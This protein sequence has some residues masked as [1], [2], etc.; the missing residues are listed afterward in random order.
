[1]A[2]NTRIRIVP[3]MML[4]MSGASFASGLPPLRVAPELLRGGAAA[5]APARAP[6]AASTGAGARPAPTSAPSVPAAASPARAPAPARAPSRTRAPRAEIPAAALPAG[7]T[8]VTAERIY[9]VRGIELVAD[10]DA[11]L[12]RADVVVTADKVTY[13]EPVDEVVAEGNVVMRQG[14]DTIEGPRATLVVG[15]RVGVVES[16]RYQLTRQRDPRAEADALRSVA[17]SGNADE[18]RLAGEN[19]YRLKNATWT[20]CESTDPDWYLRAGELDLDYD[21]EIG[22]ARNSTIVFKDVPIFYM[23]WGEFPL[24]GQRQSGLLPG[25]FGSTDKTGFDLTQP[26]YWNIA[27]NYDATIAPRIMTRRGVQLGGE[28]RYLGQA[29]Q[30]TARAEYLPQ[31]RVTGEERRLG[32]LQHQQRLADN[33]YASLDLN[34]VSDDTYFKDL[35][36]RIATSSRIN[37]LREGRLIYSG[38]WWSASALAQSYQTLS[39]DPATTNDT[40]YR[41]LPQLLVTGTRPD[42]PGGLSAT[43]EGEFVRFAHPDQDEANSGKPDATRVVAYPQLSLPLRGAAWFVTPKVG[44]HNTQYSIDQPPQTD[45]AT[46]A[47]L[48]NSISRTVPIMSLDSGLYFDRDASFFG[49]DYLQTLEPRLFYL[50]VPSREQQDI[51]IFDTNRFDVGFAQIFAENRYSGS[52]RIGDANDLTAAVVSRLIEGDSG[53]ER[54]RG[55]IGQRYYFSDQEVYLTN[56]DELR[57]AGARTDFLF[58]LGGRVTREVAVDSYLQYNSEESRTER[59]NASVR[60]QPGYARTLGLSYR[61][62]PN[63]ENIDDGSIGL[64]NVDA[65]GQWPLGGPWSGVARVTRSLKDNRLTEAIGGVEYNGGC[66]VFRVAAHRFAVDQNDVTKA[67]FVQLE[68]NDLASIGSSPLSLIKRSVPGYGKIN[69]SSSD[70]IFG[71]D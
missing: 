49:R 34:A 42:L 38:G 52:D 57:T 53:I 56:E 18:L 19:Q 40:P 68:L 51:P 37:L 8:S 63:L 64:E 22:T 61:Y 70:R 28:F 54:L 17:G 4:C 26:Y 67:L 41:R 29:Y 5:P 9:G 16:P 21:R 14:E 7:A 66:W 33:L 48:K 32:S 50:R 39:P 46:S 43:M 25:T 62:A 6:A 11:E 24:T 12:V 31:D 2:L 30:G 35:S 10:G 59:V 20:T 27:P 65:F 44:V 23:P 55:L 58:G 47:T 71:F 3:L 45:P 15:D 1:M 69:D 36:S 13:R 60:Y